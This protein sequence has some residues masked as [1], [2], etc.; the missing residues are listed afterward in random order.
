[1]DLDLS[2]T[3]V[4]GLNVRHIDRIN[5]GR[6][7]RIH[8][9]RLCI[10]APVI[11][12]HFHIIR[13][14]SESREGAVARLITASAVDAVIVRFRSRHRMYDDLAIVAVTCLF[15]G[16]IDLI[17]I[18]AADRFHMHRIADP[19]TVVVLYDH[20]IN[21]SCKS[22]EIVA[23]LERASAID[24]VLVRSK[25]VR[26]VDMDLPIAGT[27][28]TGIHHTYAIEARRLYRNVLR[29][30][31]HRTTP[32]SIKR[33]LF[34]ASGTVSDGGGLPVTRVRIPGRSQPCVIV[35]IDRR[36]TVNCH[37]IPQTD[38]RGRPGEISRRLSRRD[39]DL[40]VHGCSE[41]QSRLCRFPAGPVVKEIGVQSPGT[42][43]LGCIKAHGIPVPVVHLITDEE[44][45]VDLSRRTEMDLVIRE[46]REVGDLNALR[47]QNSTRYSGIVIPD[48]YLDRGKR[49]PVH[50][51]PDRN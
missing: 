3:P 21:A 44:T 18:H 2:I 22:R 42:T 47:I 25:T 31:V 51:F 41:V 9:D 34:I 4:T 30:A 48:L 24:A 8:N 50:S 14:G 6:G 16:N 35:H 15:V 26:S 40:G 13:A 32:V 39:E 12:A 38:V 11:I 37:T 36:T 29:Y 49:P 17:D 43:I 20:I 28:S 23:G 45:T 19:A 27:A 46:F 5:I 10:D 1:M 7:D 33:D